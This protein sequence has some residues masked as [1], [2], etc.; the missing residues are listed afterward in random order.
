MEDS[1]PCPGGNEEEGNILE[2]ENYFK[3]R[4]H[5]SVTG[6]VTWDILKALNCSFFLMQNEDKT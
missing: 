2:E 1:G 3:P 5:F 4:S 6:H